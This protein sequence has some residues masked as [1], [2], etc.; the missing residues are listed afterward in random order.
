MFSGECWKAETTYPNRESQ[1]Q[2]HPIMEP[3][4]EN[5]TGFENQLGQ[6]A[7][8]YLCLTD[9]A[10]SVRERAAL[11]TASALHL[12]CLGRYCRFGPPAQLVQRSAR[13]RQKTGLDVLY[14]FI[15]S[16]RMDGHEIAAADMN[17]RAGRHHLQFD[18]NGPQVLNGAR[19][20]R[21]AIADRRERFAAPFLVGLIQRIFQHAGAGGLPKALPLAQ[22]PGSYVVRRHPGQSFL[23][24]GS[25]AESAGHVDGRRYAG[26]GVVRQENTKKGFEP[27]ARCIPAI[28]ATVNLL[29]CRLRVSESA[30]G[31]VAS[32]CRV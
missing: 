30:A 14:W 19:T 28:S 11:N 32:R 15:A 5:I 24:H 25:V 20:A 6:E 2:A 31:S 21:T 22:R 18:G 4:H 1:V 10:E 23:L 29:G 12:Q 17:G 3:T 16:P 9:P 13:R 27:A 8:K 7:A 26:V